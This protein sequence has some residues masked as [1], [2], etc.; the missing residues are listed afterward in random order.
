[1]RG[2]TK[3]LPWASVL[4]VLAMACGSSPSAPAIPASVATPAGSPSADV[5]VAVLGVARIP[6]TLSPDR[7]DVLETLGEPFE[8]AVVVSR[9][10]CLEGLPAGAPAD[11]YVLAIQQGSR[12]EVVLLANQVRREPSFIGPVHLLCTD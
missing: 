8:G 5:W 2:W 9:T 11:G 12:A 10:A 6:G 7:N 1:M 4:V 3:R